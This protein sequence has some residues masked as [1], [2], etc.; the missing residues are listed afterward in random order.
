MPVGTIL[1]P[2]LYPLYSNLVT[3][4]ATC[5]PSAFVPGAPCPITAINQ[6]FINLGRTKIEAIDV[7]VEYKL[8]ATDVGRFTLGLQGSYYVKY[9]QQ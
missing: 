7:T 5:V 4:A 2:Q 1:D 9:E 8:P 6:Q 3:R